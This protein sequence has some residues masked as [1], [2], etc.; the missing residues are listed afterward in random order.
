MRKVGFHD[1][2]RQHERAVDP[3]HDLSY[4][5]WEEEDR[6]GKSG[7]VTTRQQQRANGWVG[8]HGWSANEDRG[9]D[10]DD[11]H[12]GMNRKFQERGIVICLIFGVDSACAA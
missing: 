12:P 10:D 2:E 4:A 3:F 7:G 5:E 1:D 8:G 9:G 11:S 6:G